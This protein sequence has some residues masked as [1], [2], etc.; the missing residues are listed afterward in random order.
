[1]KIKSLSY[2]LY[3][4][5]LIFFTLAVSVAFSQ[6]LWA[7][8][9]A[10][11]IHELIRLEVSKHEDLNQLYYTFQ[12]V[13]GEQNPAQII[14][15]IDSRLQPEK[16]LTKER[17][18]YL[19]AYSHIQAARAYEQLENAGR[20]NILEQIINHYLLALQVLNREAFPQD[21]AR[22]QKNLADVYYTVSKIEGNYD[23]AIKH[24]QLALQVFT[25]ESSRQDWAHT[26]YLLGV[27]YEDRIQGAKA[28]NLEQALVHFKQA[29]QVYTLEASPQEWANTQYWLGIIFEDRIQGEKAANQEQALAHFK[30]T[31]QV[32][33]L[34]A[35]PQDWANTHYRLG[36]VL[37]YYIP[38]ERSDSIEQAINHAQLALQVYTREKY[39]NDWGDQHRLLAALYADRTRG[40]KEENLEQAGKHIKLALQVITRKEYP[41]EWFEIQAIL[42][43]ININTIIHEEINPYRFIFSDTY[44]ASNSVEATDKID[45]VIINMQEQLKVF[46]RE[47]FPEEWGRI[48]I[49]LGFAFTMLLQGERAINL[50]KSIAHYR[51]G[52][53]VLTRDA[54]PSL[55]ARGQLGLIN[56]TYFFRGDKNAISKQE[57]S[58]SLS[59]LHVLKEDS[60]EEFILNGTMFG[61]VLLRKEQYSNALPLLLDVLKTNEEKLQQ[62]SFTPEERRRL[63]SQ[64]QGIFSI[65]IWAA[66]QSQNYAQAVGILEWSRS[67]LLRQNLMLDTAKLQNVPIK[68]QE[69]IRKLQISIS[70]L[71]FLWQQKKNGLA[72]DKLANLSTNL[73]DQRYQLLENLKTI[74]IDVQQAPSTE[75]LL[76][77][78]D[79]LPTGSALVAPVLSDFGTIVFILPAGLQQIEKSH[80]LIL[81]R[82]SYNDDYLQSY[83]NW[84]AEKDKTIRQKKK[85]EWQKKLTASLEKWN[86]DILSPLLFHLEK[87][88]IRPGANLLW[89]P[90]AESSLLPI[91]AASVEG[92]PLL[93][94]YTLQFLPSINNAYVAQRHLA[95]SHGDVL[96]TV[97]D[98]TQDLAYA[99]VESDL[100]GISFTSKVVLEAHNGS[101]DKFNQVLKNTPAYLH[102]ATH[103]SYQWHD[104][105]ES[106]LE[107]A[108]GERLKLG[109]LLSKQQMLVGSR[110]VILSACETGI[111]DIGV[112]GEAMGLP[113]AFMQ[114]G[115]PGVISTLWTVSDLSTTF[116]IGKFF[117]LHRDQNIKPPKALA[118][119]QE[120]LR[121]AT[122]EDLRDWLSRHIKKE[123]SPHLLRAVEV[124]IWLRDKAAQF[125]DQRP[126]EEPYYWAGFVYS[127]M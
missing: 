117:Q 29:L 82:F 80:V 71:E 105:L 114:A 94:R 33:T 55:W 23:L 4:L 35:S 70:D 53:Q 6:P 92:Q 60:P 37:F 103:G 124:L 119:A 113:S 101:L 3:F 61:I 115:A 54:F 7:E 123:A 16:L 108:H 112:P 96:L 58:D 111:T 22:T 13:L 74:G 73:K 79:T 12:R 59:A 44:N 84:I 120:W 49:F 27:I 21:W 97:I 39:P 20:S 87:L 66:V 28:D 50:D 106:G 100:V 64:A 9:Y 38:G 75:T 57:I 118:Q 63:V 36:A 19:W 24:Y 51:L 17:F 125:P 56:A 98:P 68:I 102:F 99:P 65:A 14:G 42:L 81:P 34:E 116:L 110:L 67:R 26:Q 8:R 5:R 32:Y 31:L 47:E 83:I 40:K 1:M 107:F 41:Q 69:E 109:Y 104:P 48:Q 18:P 52:M 10:K 46:S 45:Q 78:L 2:L 122:Y 93:K 86:K 62:I 88:S 127:G 72:S 76:K 25:Q 95:K 15:F 126:Y 121:S 11:D 77:W 43:A 85:I 90:D 91:H 89:I 30:Q